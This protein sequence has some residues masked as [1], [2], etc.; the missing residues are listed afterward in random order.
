MFKKSLALLLGL[1]MAFSF[2]LVASA[3]AID[4]GYEVDALAET[5][6]EVQA[7]A[8]V[9]FVSM[10]DDNDDEWDRMLWVIYVPE[11]GTQLSD[12][13]WCFLVAVLAWP[14]NFL[15]INLGNLAAALTEGGALEGIGTAV[16]FLAGAA[17][18]VTIAMA[19]INIITNWNA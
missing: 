6:T 19:F 5:Q 14:L 7:V 16:N 11:L 18:F 10:S 12:G 15:G 4:Y 13:L 8:E 9:E 1:L 17:V 3:E 2:A